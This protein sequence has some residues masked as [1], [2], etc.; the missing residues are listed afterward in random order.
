MCA[1]IWKDPEI[2]QIWTVNQ[3][4]QNNWPKEN[5]KKYPIKEIQIATR[6]RLRDSV[7]ESACV[8]IHTYYTLF[9]LKHLLYY[10]A[11]LWKLFAAKLKALVPDHWP[12]G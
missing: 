10:F 6:V 3:A 12:C 2:Y 5:Q 7:T 1:H 11:S 4:N 9:P 8:S